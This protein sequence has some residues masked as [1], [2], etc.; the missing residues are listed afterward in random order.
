MGWGWGGWRDLRE[1][2]GREEER[3]D[4]GRESHLLWMCA[5][6]CLLS[7]VRPRG[8]HVDGWWGNSREPLGSERRVKNV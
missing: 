6:V 3:T 8:G 7:T 5:V 2:A 4:S 1:G